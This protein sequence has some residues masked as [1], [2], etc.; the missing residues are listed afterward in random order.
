M[1]L[2]SPSP[3]C[4]SVNDM[5]N[6]GALNSYAGKN[7]HS[8]PMTTIL[9]KGLVWQNWFQGSH[10]SLT[11]KGG[12][13]H[14]NTNKSW[15]WSW[16]SNTLATGY[17][18][19]TKRLWRWERLGA[20]REGDDR[21]WDGWM[22]SPT[23]WTWVLVDSGSWWWTGRPGVLQFVGLQ[24]V[25]HDWVTELNWNTNNEI[26]AEDLLSFWES[27]ILVCARQRVPMWAAPSKNPGYWVTNDFP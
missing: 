10:H 3:H 12:L 27:G 4:P 9:L 5:L 13:M 16:N 19:L 24:R 25:G 2:H 7:S 17:E 6:C 11:D 22:A 14:L 23:Q 18:E 26:C 1:D 20:G 15:C 8:R 21:G